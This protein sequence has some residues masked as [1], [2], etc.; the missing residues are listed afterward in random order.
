MNTCDLTKSFWKNQFTRL[1]NCRSLL[2]D[3]SPLRYPGGKGSLKY[4]LANTVINNGLEGKAL[5]EPFCGGAGA[6]LP[7]LK[8]GIIRKLWINDSNPAIYAFWHSIISD[9]EAF[10]SLLHKTP[11]NIRQWKRQKEI[12]QNSHHASLLE[13]G[14]AAFYLNRTNRSG[15]IIGGPIGGMSQD[16]SYKMDCRFNKKSLSH[17]IEKIS[18]L[19][20]MICVRNL[21]AIKFLDSIPTNQ[22]DNSLVFLDPPYVRHGYNIYRN[23]CFKEEDHR[24]LAKYIKSKRWRWLLTYDDAPLIHELYSERTKGIL[25]YSYYM[26]KAKI[27][28]ELILAA[29][30]C[31]LQLAELAKNKTEKSAELPCRQSIRI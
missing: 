3:M 22:L 29:S 5:I 4:F 25:E 2:R 9:T 6:S 16:G 18:N 13:L 21:D 1:T 12:V 27:G 15:L 19:G 28:R 11:I 20:D 30:I 31:R 14:F 10:L 7:L 23:F 26:Q 17:R 8:Q 24:R